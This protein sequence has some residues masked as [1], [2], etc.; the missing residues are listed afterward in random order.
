MGEWSSLEIGY[1]VP[2]L[3]GM[4]LSEVQTPALNALLDAR[5][6]LRQ[7][8]STMEGNDSYADLLREVLTNPEAAKSLADELGDGKSE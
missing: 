7:I 3:P 4:T 1:D 5:H 2:A 6:K 8:L